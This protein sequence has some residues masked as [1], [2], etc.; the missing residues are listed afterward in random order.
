MRI[1]LQKAKAYF[2][3]NKRTAAQAALVFLE[4]CGIDCGGLPDEQ[5]YDAMIKDS[6]S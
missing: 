3:G 4:G 2:D 5:T 1:T 6:Y